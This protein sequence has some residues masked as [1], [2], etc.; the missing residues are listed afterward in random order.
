VAIIMAISCHDDGPS[1]RF[2]R[3][4][5]LPFICIYS[6]PSKTTSPHSYPPL[7]ENV[8]SMTHGSACALD[9]N[10][11]QLAGPLRIITLWLADRETK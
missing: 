2:L 9:S 5:F 4:V 10:G 8:F 7:A 6:E 3:S 11:T 1:A